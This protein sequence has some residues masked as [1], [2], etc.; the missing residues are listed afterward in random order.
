MAR[1]LNYFIKDLNRENA[2][3][4]SRIRKRFEWSKIDVTHVPACSPVKPS[5]FPVFVVCTIFLSLPVGEAV[6]FLEKLYLP[7][8][9]CKGTLKVLTNEK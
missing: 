8:V 7:N 5:N 9:Y 3:R 6:L 1:T 4:T 2:L